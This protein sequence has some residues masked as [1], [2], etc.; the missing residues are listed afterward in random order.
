VKSKDKAGDEVISSDNT[1]TT[2]AAKSQYS[3]ELQSIE[4][5]RRSEDTNYGLAMTIKGKSYLFIK[6]TIRNTSHAILRGLICTMNCWNGK[7]LVKYEVYVYHSPILPGQIFNL[8]IQ[9]ADDP[10]VDNVT[11]DFADSLG[12]EIEVTKKIAEK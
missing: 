11:I 9:T 3:L 1:F 5:G 8:D 4:W 2:A 10:T 6:V 12:K 7:T